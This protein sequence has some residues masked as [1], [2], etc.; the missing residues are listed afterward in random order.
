MTPR[1]SAIEPAYFQFLGLSR[2]AENPGY[3]VHP[4]AVNSFD[5]NPSLA[6]PP[7]LVVSLSYDSFFGGFNGF[8]LNCQ[9][10]FE[11]S[12]TAGLSAFLFRSE[13]FDDWEV[14][15]YFDPVKVGTLDPYSFSLALAWTPRFEGRSF[16]AG[17]AARFLH[18]DLVLRS[19]D[20]AAFDAGVNGLLP[21]SLRY[22]LSL[23]NV[24][25]GFFRMDHGYLPLEIAAGL[26]RSFQP[27]G[28]AFFVDILLNNRYVLGN[29]DEWLF[30]M[31]D[32]IVSGR[33]SLGVFVDMRI[34]TPR[35]TQEGVSAGF[36]AQIAPGR[37]RDLGISAV[38]RIV[39]PRNGGILHNICLVYQGP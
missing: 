9:Y 37:P 30:G 8:G 14:N 12:G 22:G 13:P 17:F 35:S 23:K 34:S 29:R 5:Y 18:E 15:E 3:A 10:G 21:W 28:K 38:Y 19:L 16:S 11:E 4:S 20:A 25:F 26:F 31:R 32:R 36:I 2:N 1:L 7:G 27:G 6:G 39:L 33:V 24:G